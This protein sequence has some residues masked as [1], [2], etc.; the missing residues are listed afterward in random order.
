MF[1]ETF[2]HCAENRTDQPRLILFC[3]IERPL[4]NRVMRTINHWVELTWMR[5]SQTENAVGDNVG[6]LNRIFEVVYRA[7]LARQGAEAQERGRVLRRQVG[8]RRPDPVLDRA[9]ALRQVGAVAALL[10]PHACSCHQRANAAPCI[11]RF[12]LIDSLSRYLQFVSFG[13]SGYC[14][15]I[16]CTPLLVW[17]LASSRWPRLA[18]RC[19]CRHRLTTSRPRLSPRPK[20]QSSQVVIF[21][22]WRP[23]SGTSRAYQAWSRVMPEVPSL[24]LTT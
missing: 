17:P 11:W 23:Y 12:H 21:L 2:I 22:A 7:R 14:A 5:A 16:R 6:L 8:D 10:R 4:T 24:L 19:R 18:M 20:Q 3:D 9:R 1:D 15:G 13:E